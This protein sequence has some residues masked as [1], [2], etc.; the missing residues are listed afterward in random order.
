MNAILGYTDLLLAGAYGSMTPAQTEGIERTHRAGQHL[1]ELVNDVLDLSKLEA[2]K[3]E[4]EVEPT[5]VPELIDDLFDTVRP[6]ASD[7]GAELRLE[8]D[9]CTD[10]I[11]IDPRR[12]RQILLNLLSNAIKF[13]GAR[14]VW[15]NCRRGDDGGIQVEVRDEG[16]G[17]QESDLPRI[18]E[19]F[20]QLS[21]TDRLGTGLGLPISRR[22]AELLGG[23]LEVDSEPGQGSTF[24]L[25]L[26]PSVPD[27]DPAEA[28]TR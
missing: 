16:P 8:H 12:V 11:E 18:F 20:V 17:I 24:R 21:G 2:G 25:H 27:A 9:G 4:I 6:L 19:E 1:L 7:S 15:V 5:S 14:P 3:L 26:P 22:L 13:G 23:R 28:G 10:P